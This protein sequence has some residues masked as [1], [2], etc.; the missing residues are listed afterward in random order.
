MD[1]MIVEPVVQNVVP[2]VA[3]RVSWGAILAGVTVALVT[4]LLLG[5]LGLAIGASTVD[6]LRENNPT[7]GLGIATGIWF[8]LTGLV[9]LFA[10]GWTAGRLASIPGTTERILHGVLAWGLATLVTFY[11]LTTAV[12]AIMGGA[13]RALGQGASLLGQGVA[14]ASPGLSDAVGG[15]LRDSGVNWDSIK[16]GARTMLRQTGKPELQPDAV[17]DKAKDAKNDAQSTA[18]G[19]AEDPQAADANFNDL[20]GRVYNRTSDVAD[21]ADRDALVNVVAARTGKSKEDASKVVDSWDKTYQQAREKLAQTKEVAERKAR[22]AGDAAARGVSHAALWS[23]LAMLGGLA[24]SA[25]GAFLSAPRDRLIAHD[26]PAAHDV[27]HS[28]KRDGRP[29]PSTSKRS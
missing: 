24:T 18:K 16:D 11:L 21:A 14:A 23:F 20:L 27:T 22:E 10:G 17:A 29:N 9:S 19:T 26:R 28:G 12:G 1:T 8:L 3:K 25:L 15:Q 13:A 4:Q 5:V 6:P 7:Q 2:T